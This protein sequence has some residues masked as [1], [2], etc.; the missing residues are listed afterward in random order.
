MTSPDTSQDTWKQLAG[1][2]AANLVKDGMLLGLG[3]GTTASAFMHALAQRIRDGLTI[4]GAVPSSQAT[5]ELATELG[6]PLTDLVSHPDLDLYIDGADEIGPHLHLIKGAG[7]ALLREKIVA[8]AAQ[9][10]I[11]IGDI[12]KQVTQLGHKYPVP[13]EVAPF[14]LPLVSKRLTA[15]G[16]SVQVRQKAGQRFITDNNNFILDCTF[17]N[18]IADPVALDARLHDIVGV[19]ET[20]LFINIA[21]QAIIGGPEG[22]HYL[23]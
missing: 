23:P 22:V 11:V 20:G 1:N 14:A 12:T 7:G 21:Q 10:F 8:T 17:R 5:A 9:R 3:T 15:L 6:V 16:A 13:V 18:G 2:A 19:V 4:S